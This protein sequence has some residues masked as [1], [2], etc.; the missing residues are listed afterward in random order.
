[1][2]PKR[3]RSD[4]FEIATVHIVSAT[5]P[6]GRSISRSAPGTMELNSQHIWVL[7]AETSV[8]SASRLPSWVRSV[9]E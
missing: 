7:R 1:M 8:A 6:A 4:L 9:P 3:G 5:V 2:D